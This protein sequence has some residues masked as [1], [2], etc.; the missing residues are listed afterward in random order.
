[1]NCACYSF[2]FQGGMLTLLRP[3]DCGGCGATGVTAAR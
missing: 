1:V 2:P 3:A